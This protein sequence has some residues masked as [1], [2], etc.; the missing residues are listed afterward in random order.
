M[1]EAVHAMSINRMLFKQHKAKFNGNS[2]IQAQD[3]GGLEQ[4]WR[5]LG[6]RA[7]AMQHS[8]DSNSKMVTKE[9]L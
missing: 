7:F 1:S 3:F 9:K 6:L 2:K 5:V 4:A 8:T